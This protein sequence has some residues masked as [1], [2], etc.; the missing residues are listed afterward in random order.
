MAS[1]NDDGH[2]TGGDGHAVAPA[3]KN[4]RDPV[5]S[6]SYGDAVPDPQGRQFYSDPTTEG[7]VSRGHYIEIYHI[8]SKTSLFF[9][10]LLTDFS[11]NFNVSHNKEQV[12]GRTDP[13]ITYQNT[14]RIIN[15]AF[16]V[17]AS[18]LQ[19]ARA[20]MD[21]ANRFASMMY[22]AYDGDGQSSSN[23]KA[24]PL[25][26]V[27]LGNLICKPGLP[28][29]E[30]TSPAE[31]AGLTCTI[32]GFKYNPSLDEGFFDPKPGILYPQAITID[33]E[34]SIIHEQDLGYGPDG[35]RRESGRYPYGGRAPAV[36]GIP[37]GTPPT[38]NQQLIRETSI[39]TELK[40]QKDLMRARYEVQKRKMLSPVRKLGKL[41]GTIHR[42]GGNS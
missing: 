34:L 14:E 36:P 12:F 10:A 15:V 32:G 9:K 42:T 8:I 27:K 35:S 40:L 21:K 30:G 19:E 3:S 22:P 4:E 33:L 1:V 29:S 16:S 31:N 20:N 5:K 37:E 13:V 41:F 6:L 24:G 2:G 26:K 25:F 11:D 23:L 38:M 7:A 17:V 28:E 18:N 39:S